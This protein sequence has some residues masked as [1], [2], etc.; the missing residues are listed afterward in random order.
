MS[1]SL[2]AI[3]RWFLVVQILGDLTEERADAKRVMQ[4]ENKMRY[5]HKGPGVLISATM[6]ISVT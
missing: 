4:H 6:S 3:N 1:V 2:N 5:P